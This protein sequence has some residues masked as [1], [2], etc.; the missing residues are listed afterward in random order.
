M[1]LPTSVI[2]V[3]AAIKFIEYQVGDVIDDSIE[4]TGMTEGGFG[5]LY[6]GFC[7]NR[8]IK[9]AIKTFR[10]EIWQQHEMDKRW[11]SIQGDL[12]DAKLPSKMIDPGEYLLF[13]FFREARLVCQS[14]V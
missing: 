1:C 2:A 8:Q 3:I 12:V 9:V 4:I 14:R 13:T 10:R 5:R 7:R 6:F 11:Q